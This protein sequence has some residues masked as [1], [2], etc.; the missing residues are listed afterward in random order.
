MCEGV[1]WEIELV[2]TNSLQE[3]GEERKRRR[4][5]DSMNRRG[6]CGNRNT[7]ISL[8]RQGKFLP[9]GQTHPLLGYQCCDHVCHCGS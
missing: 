7:I 9:T 3:A 1:R 2:S 4:E 5:Q 8:T 6:E